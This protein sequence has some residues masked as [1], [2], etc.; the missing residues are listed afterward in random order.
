MDNL[1]ANN[2]TISNIY[3]SG[4]IYT[5]KQGNSLPS[6]ITALG[7][8]NY[9]GYVEI[10]QDSSTAAGVSYKIAFYQKG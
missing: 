4:S 10:R 6:N 1:R 2:L 3:P 5:I 7:E 8:W 9:L